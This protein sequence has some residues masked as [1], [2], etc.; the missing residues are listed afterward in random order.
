MPSAVPLHSGWTMAVDVAPGVVD[1]LMELYR[2]WREECL[3]V[4]AAYK[5]FTAASPAE[6]S[7]VFA[8]YEAALDPEEA[9]CKA[10]A[11]QIRL[12]THVLP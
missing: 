7:L 11:T 10:Y 3:E 4:H 12:V 9:A 1:R 5:H 2:D 6:R 8:A